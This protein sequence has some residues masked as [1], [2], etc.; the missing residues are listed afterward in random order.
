MKKTSL[1]RNKPV[2]R[3]KP[4]ATPKKAKATVKRNGKDKPVKSFQAIKRAEG[5][6]KSL[7]VAQIAKLALAEWSILVRLHA[8]HICEWCGKP[9]TEAHHM[10]HKAQGNRFRFMVENG[11]ALCGGCHTEFHNR[12]SLKGTELFRQQR[13]GSYEKVMSEPKT[14]LKLSRSQMQDILDDLRRQIA[15]FR[16]AA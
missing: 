15:E 1:K 10:V 4:A 7:S 11:V 6:G 13:P 8:D 16:R 12:N 3:S 5:E 2:S 14:E 9:A